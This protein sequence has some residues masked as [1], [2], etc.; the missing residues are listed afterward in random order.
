MNF[1]SPS[2]EDDQRLRSGGDVS[3]WHRPRNEQITVTGDFVLT[4]EAQ[5]EYRGKTYRGTFNFGFDQTVLALHIWNIEDG[6]GAF[7]KNAVKLYTREPITPEFL[8]QEKS[9]FPE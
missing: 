7:F 1:C 4:H 6:N 5:I 9:L 3:M 2:Y 8:S